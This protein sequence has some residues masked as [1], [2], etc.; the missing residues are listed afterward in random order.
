MGNGALR[1]R[2]LGGFEVVAGESVVA[3]SAWRLR[4]AKSVLKLLA[5]APGDPRAPAHDHGDPE[6]A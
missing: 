2:L 4:R 6:M 3:E 1:I 5:L